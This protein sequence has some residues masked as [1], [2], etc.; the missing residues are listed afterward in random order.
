MDQFALW[1]LTCNLLGSEV[2]TFTYVTVLKV[3]VSVLPG[4]WVLFW[5]IFYPEYGNNE[6][7]Y[8]LFPYL[9]SGK[10]QT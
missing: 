6:Y 2:C 10:L 7:I 3:S 9:F 1:V 4:L 8:I 5:R